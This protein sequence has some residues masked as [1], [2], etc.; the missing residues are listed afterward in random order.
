MVHEMH[1]GGSRMPETNFRTCWVRAELWHP[2]CQSVRISTSSTPK[3]KIGPPCLRNHAFKLSV[4]MWFTINL[5]EGGWVKGH[6][7]ES[8]AL[9]RAVLVCLCLNA[10]S[11]A[12]FFLGARNFIWPVISQSQSHNRMFEIQ[13]FKFWVE[14]FLWLPTCDFRFSVTQRTYSTFMSTY[15]EWMPPKSSRKQA[16]PAAWFVDW[17]I[18]S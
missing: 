7:Q 15:S 11:C 13:N 2:R 3:F 9:S 8:L 17:W 10:F 5:F 4:T 12:P 14:D 1:E 16:E 6:P 18:Y